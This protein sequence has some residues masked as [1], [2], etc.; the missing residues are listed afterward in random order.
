MAVRRVV[1]Q[2]CEQKLK[3]HKWVGRKCSE[4]PWCAQEMWAVDNIVLS[5]PLPNSRGRK[6]SWHL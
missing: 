6:P 3:C 5:Y 1:L 2:C 4:G